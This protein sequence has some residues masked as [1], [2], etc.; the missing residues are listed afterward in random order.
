MTIAEALAETIVD[1]LD[2]SRFVSVDPT[3]SVADTVA[4]MQAAE[5]ASACV[6]DGPRLVG[7][8]TQRDVLHRVIGRDRDW[9]GPISGEMTTSLK[10]ITRGASLTEALDAMTTWWVRDMP[11]LDDDGHFLGNLTFHT[12]TKTIAALLAQQLEGPLAD[13]I[14]REGLAFVDFT[15]INLR[16]PVT[17][18]AD[19]PVGM[20]VHHLRNRGL[21]QVMVIDDRGHLVGVLTEFALQQKVGCE[22]IDLRTVP[23]A[24]L[25]VADP[26]TL[27]VRSSIA[28]G[29][30]T[31][32]T[33]ETS[34]V[35][36]V[37]ETGQPA[38]VA[39]FRQ[40]AEYVEAALEATTI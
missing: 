38:G 6:V 39:S 16:P 21:E 11:V 40:I 15:G 27:P 30:T 8:F 13:D 18:E 37:G 33:D 14:V 32:R 1:G 36:L 17:V 23:T 22:P 4:A 31:L 34:N 25:M 24:D 3:T 12:V 19:E 10:T 28:D 7:V 26:Q 20:A 9:S 35:T 29:I 5:L 2:L